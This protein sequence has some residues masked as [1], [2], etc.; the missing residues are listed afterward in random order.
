MRIGLLGGTFDP[1]HYAHLFIAEDARSRLELDRVLIVPGGVPPH[2]KPYA[3]SPPEQ[4]LR[5]VEL[6]LA[7]SEHLDADDTEVRASGLSY[8]VETLR[9]M[10]RRFPDH[11]IVFITGVDAVAEI[12]TWHEPDEVVR[13][14]RMVA[15][16]RPGRTFADLEDAV[17][18]RLLSRIELMVTP[19]IGISSTS[20]RSRVARGLP[21]RYLTPNHVVDYIAAHR[22]YRDA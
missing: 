15:V 10:G 3:A 16:S 2:K 6:A 21:I 8:T 20:I 13:L 18:A 4:R 17:P 19:E 22:L 12:G 5:M 7:D 9:A 14:C 1:I 11:E